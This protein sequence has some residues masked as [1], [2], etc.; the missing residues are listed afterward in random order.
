MRIYSFCPG[1]E[2]QEGFV[3]LVQKN[4]EPTDNGFNVSAEAAQMF[5]APSQATR[6]KN[7]RSRQVYR[8]PFTLYFFFFI[9]LKIHGL[10]EDE[11]IHI[12]CHL[13]NTKSINQA[14]FNPLNTEDFLRSEQLSWVFM[15]NNQKNLREVLKLWSKCLAACR[16]CFN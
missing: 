2:F 14:L 9:P 6:V 15:N 16:L 12:R 13:Q 11:A 4:L 3:V 8:C 5:M 7:N 10:T 1:A